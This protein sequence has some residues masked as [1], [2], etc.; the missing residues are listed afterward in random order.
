VL[1]L[2][3]TIG[4]VATPLATAITGVAAYRLLGVLSLPPALASLPVLRETTRPAAIARQAL[5]GKHRRSAS[6][7]D[8]EAGDAAP[9][10]N[11]AASPPGREGRGEQGQAERDDGRNP[12]PW[13]RPE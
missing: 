12:G 9:D 1:I 6:G 2:P 11:D 3:L 5:P 7:S 4:A 8:R 10:A 13:A